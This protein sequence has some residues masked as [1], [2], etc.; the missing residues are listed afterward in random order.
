MVRAIFLLSVLSGLAW[1]LHGEQDRGRFRE[2]DESFLDFLLGNARQ[3]M[4]PDPAKIND[5]VLVRLRE[6]DKDEYAAW[7]P[8]P[9]DYQMIVKNLAAYEPSV[10]VIADPLHW[11]E[12]KPE[13]ID[14]LARSLVPI[15]RIVMAASVSSD[16]DRDEASLTILRERLPIISRSSDK[17]RSLPEAKRVLAMPETALSRQADIGLV[18]PGSTAV[19]V[20]TNHGLV[21]SLELQALSNSGRVP[22]EK[23]RITTGPGAGVHFSDSWF[24]PTPA[25]GSWTAAEIE[26]PKVNALDL[27]VPEVTGSDADLTKA[28]GKGKTIILGMDR[29]IAGSAS[30]ASQCATTVATALALP[31]V[32]VLSQTGQFIAWG[33]AGGLGLLLLLWPKHKAL[34]RAVLFLFLALTASYLAFQALQVWCPPAIPSVLIAASGVLVRLFGRRHTEVPTAKSE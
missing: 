11:P 1:W 29:D 19:A 6:E 27:M 22:F 24:V 30:K 18:M 28:L 2:L 12:P 17:A 15:P 13:F 8:L 7:P 9:I 21:P 14:S 3:E 23:I 20:R 34:T 5:V 10:L 16:G 26:V 31:R 25:N 4:K 33:I 32:S